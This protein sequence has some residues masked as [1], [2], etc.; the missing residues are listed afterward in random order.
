M[1]Y[2]T[3]K[4]WEIQCFQEWIYSQN[5]PHNVWMNVTS[6]RFRRMHIFIFHSITCCKTK[7]QYMNHIRWLIITARITLWNG[8]IFLTQVVRSVYLLHISFRTKSCVT[9]RARIVINSSFYFI[10]NPTLF[11][12]SSSFSLNN[13]PDQEIDFFWS[14]LL[15]FIANRPWV[16]LLSTLRQ[17]IL[18]RIISLFHW[19]CFIY[20]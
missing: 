11:Y 14:F 3:P 16:K 4:V 13:K 18:K 9:M 10:C 8:D 7:I 2:W 20:I 17:F 5:S 19:I 12:L 1:S 15:A 6:C